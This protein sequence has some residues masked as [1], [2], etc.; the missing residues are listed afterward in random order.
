MLI[1][2]KDKV[3]DKRMKAQLS[4]EFQM[5]YLGAVRKI[6]DMEILKDRKTDR[7]YLSRKDYIEKILYRFNMLNAKAI[8]TYLA[9]HFKFSSDLCRQLDEDIDFISRIPYSTIV[10]SFM[11]AMVCTWLEL[12]C[13]IS[14]FSRYMTN[15]GK[16]L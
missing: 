14:A 11:Y 1:A 12:V 6:L 4:E 16:K 2:A 10:G 15:L 13:A 7:L 3:E 5:K 9:I 8:K